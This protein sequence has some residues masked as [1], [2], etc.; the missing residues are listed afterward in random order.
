MITSISFKVY[1]NPATDYVTIKLDEF[2][3]DIKVDLVSV[4]GK[5]IYSASSINN[6]RIGIDLSTVSKGVYFLKISA[7]R[8]SLTCANDFLSSHSRFNVGRFAASDRFLRHG[9]GEST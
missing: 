8:R 1:P 6:N 3:S 4:T 9:P 7:N 2:A 5:L